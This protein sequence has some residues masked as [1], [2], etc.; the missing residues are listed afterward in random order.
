MMT[1]RTTALSMPGLLATFILLAVS[2]SAGRMVFGQAVQE[3]P[4]DS[5]QVEIVYLENAVASEVAKTLSH[6]FANR[7]QSIVD[8]VADERLNALIIRATNE[9]REEIEQLIRTLD[10]S[11]TNDSDVK[12]FTLKHATPS[13][14][15]FESLEHVLDA[16]TRISFDKTRNAVVASGPASSLSV[17][18]AL[19]MR[20]DQ[21][22]T[23]EETDETAAAASVRVRIV[24][25][26]ANLDDQSA[27]DPPADL[28]NVMKELEKIGFQDT[29][30]VAQLV[31][32]AVEGERFRARGTTNLAEPLNC[33]LDVE[34][35]IGDPRGRQVGEGFHAIHLDVSAVGQGPGS[36]SLCQLETAIKTPVGQSVVLGVTPIQS[37]QSAFVVQVLE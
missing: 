37:K 10:V 27:S 24:W 36:S 20:L 21:M 35:T 8:V 4:T 9:T 34:G 13:S 26:V 7:D 6:V 14:E 16:R 17:I 5:R 19:L 30:M 33:S 12:I 29:K 15:L 2:T 3:A 1:K 22:P 11:P 25:L 18:E 32:Q 23:G 28:D 31:V